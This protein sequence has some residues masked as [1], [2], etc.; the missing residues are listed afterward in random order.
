MYVFASHFI[1]M[2]R[3]SHRE[4]MKLRREGH[5]AQAFTKFVERDIQLERARG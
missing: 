1:T 3:R 2:A 5:Y 4:A